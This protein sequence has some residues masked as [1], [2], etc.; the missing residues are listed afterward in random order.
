MEAHALNSEQQHMVCTREM[1][2]RSLGE[3]ALGE[4]QLQ[5]KYLIIYYVKLL[6]A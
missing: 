6:Q 4:E 2:S 1:N 3:M 5:N